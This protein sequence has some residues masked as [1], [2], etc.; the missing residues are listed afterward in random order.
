MKYIFGALAGACLFAPCANATAPAGNTLHIANNGVDSPACGAEESPCRSI[1][2]GIVNATDG[3]TLLVRPGKYGD[4]DGSGSID[5]P[6]EEFGTTIPGS[7]AGV[8][9]NKRLTI[10]STAGAEATAINMNATSLAAVQIAA[11]G[12]NFGRRGAGFTITGS[13]ANGLQA[14]GVK[15]VVISGN[16]ASK[17]PQNGFAVIS[18]DVVEVR[19]NTAFGNTNTGFAAFGGPPGASVLF[20]NNTSIG[21]FYGVF[22]NGAESPHQVIGNE[23]TSNDIGLEAVW[24]P[25]RISQNNISAN[26]LGMEFFGNTTPI[27]KP[28]LVVRNNFLGNN[29]YGIEIFEG[30]PGQLPRVRENN[31]FGNGFCGTNNRTNES[32]DARNNFWGVATGPSDIDPADNACAESAPTRTVPFATSEF[33]V[34]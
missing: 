1:S 27:A 20:V 15:Q 23:I 10:I 13:Q 22:T 28:P 30:P 31:F 29:T 14:Y 8:Y 5:R 16:I 25:V 34:R 21:N 32:L 24:G 33:A 26:N 19:G 3:D 18:T 17:L 6:G 9:V 4:N 12:V 11:D 7:E 2:Q